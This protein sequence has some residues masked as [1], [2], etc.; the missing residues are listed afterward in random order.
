MVTCIHIGDHGFDDTIFIDDECGAQH[1]LV[2]YAK[3]GFLPPYTVGLDSF[4]IVVH[5]QRKGQVMFFDEILVS[6]GGVRAYT[7]NFETGF[8]KFLKMVAQIASFF[9]AR[10]G[11]VLGIEVQ[12]EFFTSKLLQC[13][14]VAILIGAVDGWGGITFFQ[15]CHSCNF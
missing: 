3:K 1:A 10:G 11:V 7:Q 12:N 4:H 14:R 13:D 15:M 6:A 9:R 2:F 5:Q 8:S